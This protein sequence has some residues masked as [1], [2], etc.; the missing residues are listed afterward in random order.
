MCPCPIGLERAA[1]FESWLRLPIEDDFMTHQRFAAPVLGDKGEQSGSILFHLL[2]PGGK[3]HTEMS[4]LVSPASFCNSN[5]HKLLIIARR[6]L[7]ACH[8]KVVKIARFHAPDGALYGIF[9]ISV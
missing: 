7:L 5:F 3:W 6:I 4:N 1:Q 9:T 8:G 2:V